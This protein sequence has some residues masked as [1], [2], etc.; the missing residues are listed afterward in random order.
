[1]VTGRLI[2]TVFTAVSVVVVSMGVVAVVGVVVMVVIRVWSA[3]GGGVGNQ[4]GW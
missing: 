2:R 3:S 4:N 1:M